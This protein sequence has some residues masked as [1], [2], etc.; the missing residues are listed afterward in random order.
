M[1]LIERE[2][3]D[4]IVLI[5]LM[6]ISALLL[7]A[8]PYISYKL[9]FGQLFEAVSTTASGW[10]GA[11]TATGIELAGVSYGSAL[12]RQASETRIEGQAQAETGRAQAG[13]SAS[14]LQAR[15]Q[16]LLGLQSAAASRTQSLGAIVGGYQMALRMNEAQRQASTGMIEQSRRQQVTNIG[17]DRSF[18]QSQ[19]GIQVGREERDLRIGQ[20][21]QNI[22]T[23]TQ[24]T[25]DVADNTMHGLARLGGESMPL[26]PAA[27][28]AAKLLTGPA[29]GAAEI[30][31]NNSTTDARVSSVQ[32][33]GQSSGENYEYTARMR[34]HAANGY[35]SEA[36]RITSE[37]AAA[38]NASARVQRDLS[39]GGVQTAYQQQVQ[40]VSGAY[41]LNLQANQVNLDGALQAAQVMEESG[42]KA[43]KLEQMSQIVH[44]LSR[45]VARRAELAMTLRY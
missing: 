33:A 12:Q 26:L 4:G 1:I 22:T 18:G 35:A 41:Q 43:V 19:T 25:I 23:L 11:L 24:R 10:M 2:Q 17:A 27:G 3:R 8:S 31:I 9:A 36:T 20:S 21:Q 5:V 13:R 38:N 44:T 39:A 16:Q 34:E 42:M 7:L 40:G 29:R 45:D 14:D 15:G 37:Q 32:M 30:R 28:D 6:I